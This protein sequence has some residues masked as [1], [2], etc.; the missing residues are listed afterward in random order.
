[1]HAHLQVRIYDI[2]KLTFVV[3]NLRHMGQS[4]VFDFIFYWISHSLDVPDRSAGNISLSICD[5][6]KKTQEWAEARCDTSCCVYALWGLI[7]FHLVS[8][9]Y[10]FTLHA[11][12]ES[13]MAEKTHSHLLTDITYIS[14]KPLWRANRSFWQKEEINTPTHTHKCFSVLVRTFLWLLLL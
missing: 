2:L 3:N 1:M 5:W 12:W 10:R 8:Q 11:S 7:L 13:S 6:T 9:A 14:I 4:R